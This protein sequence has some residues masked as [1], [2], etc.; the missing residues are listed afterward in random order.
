MKLAL[1]NIL[2]FI[3]VLGIQV[4]LINNLHFLGICTPYIYIVVLMLLPVRIPRWVEMLIGAFVGLVIDINCNSLGTHMAACILISYIRPF[5]IKSNVSDS[6]RISESP[7]SMSIGWP[8]YIK[9]V[10]TL[11]IIHHTTLFFLAAFSLHHF[12]IT[13]LQIVVS[14]IVTIGIILGAEILKY[15]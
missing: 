11:T 4:V 5:F 15:R 13:I 2:R 14:S 1:T 7:D 10:C 6:E 3:L 9:M 8:N 12:W